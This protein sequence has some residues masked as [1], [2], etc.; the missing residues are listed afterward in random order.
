MGRWEEFSKAATPLVAVGAFLWGI[1]T[2]QDTARRELAQQ[3]TADRQF[4]ETRRIEATKPYLERQLQ[5]Y[6]EAV[7]VTAGLAVASPKERL[8]LEP[9]FWKLYWGKL[10]LVED[11]DVAGAMVRMGEILLDP[12]A[13]QEQISQAALDIAHAC[14]NDIAEAWNVDLWRAPGSTNPGE[15]AAKPAE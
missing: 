4:G 6:T 9:R 10:A 15:S 13:T 8:T 11:E 14:R 12:E 1:W 5:L 7:E 3:A 2:Y